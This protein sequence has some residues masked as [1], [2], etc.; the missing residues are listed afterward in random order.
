[1]YRKYCNTLIA[2]IMITSGTRVLAHAQRRQIS[3]RN[4]C[5]EMRTR[6]QTMY[7]RI[8]VERIEPRYLGSASGA[9]LRALAR[10]MFPW[11]L[12]GSPP[13]RRH[14]STV[15]IPS[16]IYHQARPTLYMI[17][18]DLRPVP[19][20]AVLPSCHAVQCI[21]STISM[22]YCNVTFRTAKRHKG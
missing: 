6:I 21:R 4:L 14:S 16:L 7:K 2:H 1:M 3:K 19:F 12:H 13:Y 15:D 5:I 11:V 18:V 22:V 9:A 10:E 17:Y 8:R 20:R